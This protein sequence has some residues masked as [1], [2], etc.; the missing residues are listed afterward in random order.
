MNHSTKR[1]TDKFIKWCSLGKNPK[2]SIP[3]HSN[4]QA[5][6]KMETARTFNVTIC[7]KS[8]GNANF[9]TDV[10][11]I[12]VNF[13]CV[14]VCV[15]E[16][17]RRTQCANFYFFQYIPIKST[18]HLKNHDFNLFDYLSM[19][20]WPRA[21]IWREK[22]KKYHRFLFFSVSF[23]FVSLALLLFW[24]LPEVKLTV[25]SFVLC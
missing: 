5:D 25:N 1:D 15:C 13:E 17:V 19:P 18:F 9:C 8:S 3:C 7:W 12:V 11:W 20:F 21:I 23:I 4:W 14:C 22:K 6:G 16:C 10:N 2:H 24:I